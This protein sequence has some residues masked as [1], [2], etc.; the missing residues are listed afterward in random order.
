MYLST[1]STDNEPVPKATLIYR[2]SSEINDKQIKSGNYFKK[3]YNT[4]RKYLR[5]YSVM[6]IS[7]L[8]VLATDAP[9]LMLVTAATAT[10]AVAAVV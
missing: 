10:A 7:L 2:L 1:H 6:A 4:C 3:Y 9:R 5:E 8:R